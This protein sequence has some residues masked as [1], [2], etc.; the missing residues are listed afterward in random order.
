[1]SQLV[2]PAQLHSSATL[3]DPEAQQQSLLL[4][5]QAK[6]LPPLPPVAP[7]GETPPGLLEA[8]AHFAPESE[9]EAEAAVPP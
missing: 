7:Q 8:Q 5:A 6:M 2:A 9:V 1:M 3:R 4:R